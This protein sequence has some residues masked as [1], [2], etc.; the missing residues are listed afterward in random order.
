[1]DIAIF[2]GSLCLAML[3]GLTMK[4]H[5]VFVVPQSLGLLTTNK[6]YYDSMA[7]EMQQAELE[8]YY[9]INN[10]TRHLGSNQK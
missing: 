6:E 8:S 3:V 7:K 5:G 10:T 9:T 2:S 1:M 4:K